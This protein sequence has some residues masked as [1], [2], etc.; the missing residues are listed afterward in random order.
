MGVL[1]I[2]QL[3]LSLLGG[4]STALGKSG[5]TE[6]AVGVQAAITSL[7]QVHGSLVTQEQVESLKITPQW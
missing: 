3:I 2:I 7:E 5:L 4:V 6:A 1:S